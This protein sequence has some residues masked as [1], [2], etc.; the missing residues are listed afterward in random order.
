MARPAKARATK[1]GHTTRTEDEQRLATENQ[2]RGNADKLLPPGYLTESQVDIFEFVL[3][4][5]EEAKILG[6]LDVFALAQLAVCTDRLRKIEES[7]NQNIGL[8]ENT[9]LMA[10]RDRYAKDFLRLINEF[11]LSPQSRAKLSI[12]ALKPTEKKKTLMD[13]INED[14]GEEG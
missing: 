1:T 4:E 6:N 11:C 10:S 2:L 7:V 3:N 13:L 14:D 5:L 8:I 9:K 12:S